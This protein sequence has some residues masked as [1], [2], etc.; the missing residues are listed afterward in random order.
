MKDE[1]L[2]EEVKSNCS[3]SMFD[4]VGQAN[5]GATLH[6]CLP[7]STELAYNDGEP[8]LIQL[9]GSD[10][11]VFTLETQKRLQK[12][13]KDQKKGIEGEED[14]DINKSIRQSCRLLAK[15]TIGWSGIPDE[16]GTGFLKFTPAKA[17]E[18]YL[19][20]K[21]IRMQV[22]KFIS[23]RANFTKA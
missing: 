13:A 4:S 20:Y 22:D 21:D 17:E 7:D 2:N 5:E 16:K 15:M 10:S 1:Q 8:L 11:D 9:R 19:N 6:L 18:L 12:N 14:I 23:Q 3:L